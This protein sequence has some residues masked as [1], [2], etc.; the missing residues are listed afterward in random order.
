MYWLPLGAF[1]FLLVSRLNVYAILAAGWSS[2]RKYTL[3]AI[4]RAIAQTISYEVSIGVLLL[5]PLTVWGFLNFSRM[6]FAPIVWPALL[7]PNILP[8]WFII[9]LAET[10]RRPFDLTEGESELVSGYNTEYRGGR[11]TLL[12]MAEYTNILFVSF[13]RR[14]LLIPPYVS[15]GFMPLMLALGTGF[16]LVLFV[17]VRAATPRMRYDRLI[18]LTWKRLLPY[19]LRLLTMT[20]GLITLIRKVL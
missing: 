5:S 13:I 3:L 17:V 19:S 12:F 10:H 9:L 7:L 14:A 8:A 1:G 2:N 16:F 20:L 6:T 18:Q 15:R 4:V 11:F